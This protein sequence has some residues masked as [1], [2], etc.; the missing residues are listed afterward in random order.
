M[1]SLD[2]THKKKQKNFFREEIYVLSKGVRSY[3][4]FTEDSQRYITPKELQK[5]QSSFRQ[6]RYGQ[7]FDGVSERFSSQKRKRKIPSFY[8]LKLQRSFL[9]LRDSLSDVYG[10]FSFSISPLRAW[11][12]SLVGA[13]LFGM[14]SMSMIYKSFGQNASAQKEGFVN[15]E[16]PYVEMLSESEGQVLGEAM[17]FIQKEE[18]DYIAFQKEEEEKI[19]RDQEEKEKKELE[20]KQKFRSTIEEMVKGYPIEK[21]LP[22]I[23]KQD[24]IVAAYLIAIA[25]KES[26]WGKRVPVLEGKDC[27]NYWGYRAIR[28]R[29]GTGGHTCF[30]DVNDAVETVGARIAWFVYQK[31]LK[32]PEQLIVWK[33]GFSCAGHDDYGVEKWIRDVDLYFSKIYKE[34]KKEK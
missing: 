10:N 30:N 17:E 3:R 9:G 16:V 28:E 32:T 4:F 24:D 29:M 14:V 11:N 7:Y 31:K 19:Q 23:F 27:L 18:V 8:Q 2:I 1:P 22:A 5:I 25:K 20:Q 26:N 33:C 15:Q 6:I 13:I 12:F 34:E 21:M